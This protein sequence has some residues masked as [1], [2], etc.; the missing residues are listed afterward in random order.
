MATRIYTEASDFDAQQGHFTI[1]VVD[2]QYYLRIGALNSEDQRLIGSLID[3]GFVGFFQDDVRIGIA[4]ISSTYDAEND[5]IEIDRDPELKTEDAYVIRFT[6]ARPGE[7]GE[8]GIGTPGEGGEHAE[9]EIEDTDTGIRVRG[10]SGGELDFGPWQDVRDGIDGQDGI[11]GEPGQDGNDGQH[12]EIEVEDTNT[13]IRVRGKS[14]GEPDF[15]PW[16]DVRDGIDGEDGKDGEPGEEGED[17]EHAE[18]EIEDTPSDNENAPGIRVRGKSGGET[19]FSEWYYVQDG[20]DGVGSEGNPLVTR[21]E[22]IATSSFLTKNTLGSLKNPERADIT[23]TINTTNYGDP[24]DTEWGDTGDEAYFE[25]H[26]TEGRLAVP[27]A[28]PEENILGLWAVAED[29]SEPEGN[30]EIYEV[31]IPWGLGA[32][33]S[34]S[35][36]FGSRHIIHFGRASGEDPI[37]G[38]DVVVYF[39]K[40]RDYDYKGEITI[41]TYG[42]ILPSAQCRVKIYLAGAFGSVY[43]KDGDA[44]Y[45]PNIRIRNDGDRRVLQLYE[46][47]G[48]EGDTPGN[49][50]RYLGENGLVTAIEDAINIRGPAGLDGGDGDEGWSP[51]FATVPHGERRVLQVAD[52]FGGGGTKPETGQYIGATGF[53]AEIADGIDI[54]GPAGKDGE[55]GGTGDLTA[56]QRS[57]CIEFQAI[58]AA[59]NNVEY[60]AV[61]NVATSDPVTVLYPEGST[62]PKIVTATGGASSVTINTAGIYILTW[63]AV[64][65]TSEW[66]KT[67][68]LAIFENSDTPGTDDPLALIATH[69]LRYSGNNRVVRGTATVRILSDNTILKFHTTAIG[70]SNDARFSV[71]AGS[72]VIFEQIGVKGLDG[73]DGEPGRDGIDSIGD[74]QVS[75]GLF[76]PIAHRI[77]YRTLQRVWSTGSPTP[78]LIV[79][80]NVWG[81]WERIGNIVYFW[82]CFDIDDIVNPIDRAIIYLNL[83]QG[84]NAIRGHGVASIQS[85]AAGW[86]GIEVGLGDKNVGSVDNTNPNNTLTEGIDQNAIRI[87]VQSAGTQGSRFN[88]TIAVNGVYR[89]VN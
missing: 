82:A 4:G 55:D 9:I 31:F 85:V 23:W 58:A 65:D 69:Y 39:R 41:S 59:N 47:V 28:R 52:W 12:A 63:E 80:S 61:A 1:E 68:A 62:T 77:A 25:A 89:F 8:G 76:T 15:G 5:R 67:P 73:A 30:R 87:K 75:S 33:E 20:K 27:Y 42:G 53:V 10:K 21:G 13:G 72:K 6:Q 84:N 51:K 22:L 36:Y 74:V 44:G 43:E 7:D 37:G 16:Q 86:F 78:G 3:D 48:G 64:I 60:G 66:R 83:P 79:I 26:P 18:I 56:T 2:N 71:D 14:G 45:S 32:V 50:N 17:G 24:D 46:W 49:L 57:E 70:E 38:D 19:D 54:R 34:G 29:L 88:S 40:R 11:D 35:T 81:R